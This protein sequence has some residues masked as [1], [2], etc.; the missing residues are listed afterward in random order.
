LDAKRHSRYLTG[1]CG[2]LQC[3]FGSCGTCCTFGALGNPS[4]SDDNRSREAAS[5]KAVKLHY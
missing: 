4:A 3:F 1:S 5:A 2:C